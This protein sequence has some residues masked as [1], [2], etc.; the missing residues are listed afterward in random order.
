MNDLERLK[1][2][3][4]ETMNDFETTM[5]EEK[6]YDYVLRM[7]DEIETMPYVEETTITSVIVK[8]VNES[9]IE[10]EIHPVFTVYVEDEQENEIEW[11]EN[12]SKKEVEM[13]IKEIKT[14][15]KTVTIKDKRI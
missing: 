7:I 9:M 2:K 5:E 12:L 14:N 11:K 8:I 13:Y 6:V 3:I 10:D 1:E 4:K 15:Y